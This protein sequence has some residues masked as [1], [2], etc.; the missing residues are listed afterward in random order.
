MPALDGVPLDGRSMVSALPQLALADAASIVALPFA[1][2]PAHVTR[3][4]VGAG[5][6]LGA[7]VLAFLVLRRLERGGY[8]RRLHRVSEDRGLAIE[9]RVSLAALFALAALAQATHVSVM[10]AGFALGLAFAAVGEP[11]RLAKQLF[12]LTEGFFAPIFYVWLGASVDLRA[13]VA[14]PRAILLGLALG[15]IALLAHGLMALTRQPL[16]VALTTAAQLGVPVAAV[17]TGTHLGILAPGEDAAMLL[18]ALL[19][20]AV[21]AAMTGPVAAV[22]RRESAAA[23]AGTAAGGGPTA[24]G[25]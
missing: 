17:T 10:L 18:G 11:R 4:L 12:A 23:T 5:L 1:V 22:A 2:D 24:A 21:S 20:I 14:H 13:L 8:R 6:V 19:T 25:A 15:G 9:L 16:P 3:A 7:A